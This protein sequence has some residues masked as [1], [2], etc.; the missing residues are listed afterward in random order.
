MD[1]VRTPL[2]DGH[3]QGPSIVLLPALR[4]LLQLALSVENDEQI[5]VLFIED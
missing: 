2:M 5:E 3:E 1:S 4:R